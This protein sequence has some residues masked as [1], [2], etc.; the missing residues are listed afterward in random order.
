MALAGYQPDRTP[1]GAL[2]AIGWNSVTGTW[3]SR[4]RLVEIKAASGQLDRSSL[5]VRTDRLR[6][7]CPC[8]LAQL[9]MQVDRAVTQPLDA[10]TQPRRSSASWHAA[11]LRACARTSSHNRVMQINH[12]ARLSLQL[13]R[14]PDASPFPQ[15]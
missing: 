4:G 12:S 10:D 3:V 5:R 8:A 11:A 15:P 1:T 7:S 6:K 2:P 9:A 13:I 14:S